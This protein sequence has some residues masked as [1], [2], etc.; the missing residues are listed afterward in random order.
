MLP[1]VTIPAGLLPM[2]DV[3]RGGFGASTFATFAVLVTGFLG[4]TGRRTVTGMW[5]SAGLGGVAHHARA[6][7][8]FSHAVWDP[9]TVGLLLARAVLAVFVPADAAVTVVV[10]DTLFHRYG[11]R[12]FGC[13]WQHDGS[14]RGRDGIGRGNCFVIAGIVAEVAW[15][16]RPVFF[17]ILFRLYQPKNGATKPELAHEMT[18][19][20]TRAVH[21]RRLHLVVDAAYRSP[22][23]RRLP[24]AVTFTTR[25]ASNAVLYA[26]APPPTGKR[27]R[28]RTK[29]ERLGTA[30]DLAATLGFGQA[31]IT[32]YGTTATVQLAQTSC[33]WYG[34]LHAVA[35]R[36][37]L[38]RE[39]GSNK[40]YDIAL[41]TTDLSTSAEAI[42]CRYAR[43]W[44]V[45]QSI[46]DGKDLLGAGDAQN[47]LPK[48]VQRTVPFT[49]LAQTI[50]LLW[51]AHAGNTEADI[52]ARRASAPWYQHKTHVS[53][54]D[55]LIAFR[56]ARITTV[57]AA[58][59]AI[60]QI[61]VTAETSD[62]VAA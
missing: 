30:A 62:P 17:P 51:Y 36:V 28:P 32:R 33:L 12:V 40:P 2:L 39:H 31:T 13:F 18:A 10:D 44:S 37:I 27:G 1:A 49:M 50:L 61:T 47:R 26:P 60:E 58:H 52:A 45:E 25:L 48:A 22:V 15:M 21:P 59:A 11:R 38:V 34:S 19:V 46:K 4:A 57:P 43:R 3:V 23:W 29:G 53:L 5:L 41:V 24:A 6:H 54:D 42:V 55:M 56:R 16:N 14:A 35:V 9:D 20:L 7:R 8:F